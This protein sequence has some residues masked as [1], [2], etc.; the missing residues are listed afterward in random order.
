M[1][2]QKR[3][4]SNHKFTLFRGTGCS[5]AGNFPKRS[6]CCYRFRVEKFIC[7]NAK[8]PNDAVAS[9]QAGCS[10]PTF[11]SRNVAFT[12]SDTFGQLLPGKPFFCSSVF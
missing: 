4:K 2:F 10:L 11:N 1:L 6:V 7:G 12:F 9:F 5:K 3:N 8:T